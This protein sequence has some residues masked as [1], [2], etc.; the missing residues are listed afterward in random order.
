MTV[1][2]NVKGA[3]GADLLAGIRAS[4]VRGINRAIAARQRQIQ[5]EIAMFGIHRAADV[6]VRRQ[7]EHA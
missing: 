3:K 6:W 1:V 5:R 4:L 2:D 7:G